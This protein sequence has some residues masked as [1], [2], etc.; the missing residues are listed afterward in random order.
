MP[1]TLQ[2]HICGRDIS[3]RKDLLVTNKKF[4]NFLLFHKDCYQEAVAQG[5]YFGRPANGLARDISLAIIM[6]VAFVFYLQTWNIML[7][8]VLIGTSFYR[9]LIWWRFERVLPTG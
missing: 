5:K 1:S 4:V 7:L 8:A 3:Q 6:A 9:L 2:C